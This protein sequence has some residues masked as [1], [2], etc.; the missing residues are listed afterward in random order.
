MNI[1]NLNTKRNWIPMRIDSY[2][3]SK[4][5]EIVVPQGWSD[6]FVGMVGSENE[7]NKQW[8]RNK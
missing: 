4:K 1:P 8:R 7:N 3:A 2:R 5:F 6:K